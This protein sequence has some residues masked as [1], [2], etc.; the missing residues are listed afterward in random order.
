MVVT[1]STRGFIPGRGNPMRKALSE[2]F[3]SRLRSLRR[4]ARNYE[5]EPLSRV[6]MWLGVITVY[7]VLS[8]FLMGHLADHTGAAEKQPLVPVTDRA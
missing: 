8:A 4:Q 2:I 7:L 5:S 6:E 1:G 3:R